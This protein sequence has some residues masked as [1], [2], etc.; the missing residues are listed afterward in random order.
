MS[1]TSL[2][3]FGGVVSR[4]MLESSDSVMVHYMPS[5]SSLRFGVG[6]GGGSGSADD[7]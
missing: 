7:H 1:F 4:E 5:C 2:A 6:C 3:F